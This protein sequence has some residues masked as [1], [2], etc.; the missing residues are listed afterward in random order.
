MSRQRAARW[1]AAERGIIQKEKESR[2]EM[3]DRMF[4]MTKVEPPKAEVKKDPLF[5]PFTGI[6]HGS[7]RGAR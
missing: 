5:N 4:E 2:M 7:T 3:A 1:I 6:M